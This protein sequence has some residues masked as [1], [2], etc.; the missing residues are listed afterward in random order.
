MMVIPY[1]D[2]CSEAREKVS[3]V[4]DAI[5]PSS[6]QVANVMSGYVLTIVRVCWKGLLNVEMRPRIGER[7][8]LGFD[9]ARHPPVTQ[10]LTATLAI[11]ARIPTEVVHLQAD[12]FKL[13]NGAGVGD[14]DLWGASVMIRKNGAF[15]AR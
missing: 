12:S 10:G 11:P 15:K 2:R 7:I 8:H 6:E 4:A 14:L 1:V 9:G 3:P 5:D 13:E